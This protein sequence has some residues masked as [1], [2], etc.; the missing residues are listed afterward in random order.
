MNWISLVKIPKA[1]FE[2][3]HTSKILT[4]G[5]CFADNVGAYLTE[6]KFD[7]LANPFG[8]VFNIVSLQNLLEYILKLKKWDDADFV[9][10]DDLFFHYDFHTEIH[11]TSKEELKNKINEIAEATNAFLISSDVLILTL[12]TSWAYRSKT[13]RK[14][15]ANCHKQ[16]FL[17]FEKELLNVENQTFAFE[18]IIDLL[19]KINPKIQITLT[20]SPVRHVKDGLS[21]NSVSKALLRVLTNTIIEKYEHCQYFPSF[22]IMIDELRDYR[23][24]ASDLIHPSETAIGYITEK[25]SETYFSKKTQEICAEWRKINESRQHRPL[26]ASSKAHQLFLNKLYDKVK[27]FS[28][29]F[30]VSLEQELIK[31]QII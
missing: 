21:E 30:D 18:K 13:T 12:G 27:D 28:E 8:N 19:N 23:F 9:E 7:V 10:R 3:L 4:L 5:S 31:Q 15:V 14:I 17:E 20:V 24:Y 16:P 26:N 22:E 1:V 11:A 25:F 6:Y 2:I 29:H